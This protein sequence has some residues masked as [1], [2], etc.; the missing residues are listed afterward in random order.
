MFEEPVEIEVPKWKSWMIWCIDGLPGT[1]V[2]TTITLWALFG[3]D[4][5]LIG[6]YKDDDFGDDAFGHLTII[7]LVAFSLELGRYR[8]QYQSL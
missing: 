1:L 6:T 2:M 4:I 3:D 8:A 7:C 5:R